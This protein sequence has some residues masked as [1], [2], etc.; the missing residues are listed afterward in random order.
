MTPGAKREWTTFYDE[1]AAEHAEMTGE[2]AAAWSKLEGYAAR[3]ALVVHCVSHSGDDPRAK[4]A[5]LESSSMQ[6]GIILS[7]WFAHEARRLYGLLAETEEDRERREL[8]EL[9]R[10]CEGRITPRKLAQSNRRYKPP[11]EAESALDML[12]EARVGLWE[13]VPSRTNKA[14]VFVLSTPSTSTDSSETSDSRESV[15]VDTAT[16]GES[17]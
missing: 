14:R 13:I 16:R 1:H 4:P 6:A 17:A 7:R 8:V 3:L 12:A 15:D 5:H 11:G 2:L 9:I 10:R